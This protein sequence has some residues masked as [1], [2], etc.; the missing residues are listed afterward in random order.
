MKTHLVLPDGQTK[1]GVPDEHWSWAGKFAAEKKPDTIINIGDFADMPS[2][3]SFDVG[4][5]S[6]EGRRYTD[7]IAATKE[8]MTKFTEPI[9]KEKAR[10]IRNKD[11][12]WSPKMILTLG[13]HEERINRAINTDRKLEGLISI[14]DLKY[15]E[16]GWDV[17]PFLEVVV[18]DGIAYSHYFV[19]GA[20]GRPV[21]S[22]KALTTKKHMSCIMGHVQKTEIDMSQFRADG[23]PIIS[24]FSGAF[25]QHDEEYLG[26]QGNVHHR[27][28][29]MLYEVNKGSF[30]PHFISMEFL[31]SKYG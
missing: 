5:M 9:E 26:I 29:W 10:L 13:N 24:I 2:L 22:A 1:A 27:G 6:F 23:T 11:K 4:K 25:Y 20:M 18:E 19:S 7:D 30:W 21:T 14:D 17:H 31:R 28:I 8:A 15:K 12:R 16:F 3:S